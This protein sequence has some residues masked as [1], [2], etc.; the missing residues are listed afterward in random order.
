MSPLVLTPAQEKLLRESSPASLPLQDSKG[1][2]VGT[3]I[4][5]A[6]QPIEP[7]RLSV[8]EIEELAR[9]MSM[10]DARWYSTA[11]VLAKLDSLAA[12]ANR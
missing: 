12:E 11:E 2:I 8:D 6:E 5:R 3:A 10:T 4:L 7:V 1:N 9:R